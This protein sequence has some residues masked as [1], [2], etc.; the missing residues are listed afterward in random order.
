MFSDLYTLTDFM[1]S[2]FM[3]LLIKDSGTILTKNLKRCYVS[4]MGTLFHSYN[5]VHKV[6]LIW[7]KRNLDSNS[8]LLPFSIKYQIREVPV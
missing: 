6:R 3:F 4:F 8:F 2:Y 5:D 7:R 1:S